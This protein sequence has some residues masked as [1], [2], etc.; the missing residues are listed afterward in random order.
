MEGGVGKNYL[1]P[2]EQHAERSVAEQGQ[3]SQREQL[4]ASLKARADAQ[5]QRELELQQRQTSALLASGRAHCDG[6]A[7]HTLMA[8]MG[9]GGGGS[10]SGSGSSSGRSSGS[11]RGRG[12]SS[13]GRSSGG[14][15][16]GGGSSASGGGGQQSGGG[17]SASGG[18]S[19]EAASGE[20][21]SAS[22][23]AGGGPSAASRRG[24]G[25]GR[26][27]GGKGL[28]RKKQDVGSRNTKVRWTAQ[29]PPR[30][31]A[32][33]EAMIKQRTSSEFSGC[34]ANGLHFL[35][36]VWS[37]PLK[38]VCKGKPVK[39][40]IIAQVS[41]GKCAFSSSAGSQCLF[42]VK[43][44]RFSSSSLATDTRPTDDDDT[45]LYQLWV[46]H[47]PH[48]DH[49]MSTKGAD[50]MNMYMK[51]RVTDGNLAQK[52]MFIVSYLMD[53]CGIG[54]TKKCQNA[55]L[56][57]IGSRKVAVYGQLAA[58]EKRT[59]GG[60]AKQILNLAH[61]GSDDFDEHATFSLP[62]PIIQ[63][64]SDDGSTPARLAV[65]L[66]TENLLRQPYRSMQRCG[67]GTL[68]CAHFQ[69]DTTWKLVVE[70]HGTILIGLMS[71]DQHFHAIAYAVVNLEDQAGHDYVVRATKKAVEWVIA[72]HIR[73]QRPI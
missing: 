12:S 8:M 50:H 43:V 5:W 33:I 31:K 27:R 13:S 67:T 29:G 42:K 57:W 59:W 19:S 45:A 47:L 58:T 2:S 9:G 72:K 6:A 51:S 60:L 65:V 54:M 7:A 26:G 30:S 70:G 14:Q 17:S 10:G 22:A 38:K 11:G 36:S 39:E 53:Q 24:Q 44:I 61:N 68:V 52:P 18:G 15:Q 37:K 63:P 25:H 71:P 4:N 21:L 62:D 46:A 48:N 34:T 35:W 56:R 1:A 28:K 64:Q 55:A 20:N 23:G 66:T 41:F 73:L 32:A 3:E 16:S 40:G 69:I 49:A